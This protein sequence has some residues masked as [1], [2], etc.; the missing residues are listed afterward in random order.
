MG[1]GGFGE[2][3]C[4]CEVVEE[5]FSTCLPTEQRALLPAHSKQ[6]SSSMGKERVFQW[7]CDCVDSIVRNLQTVKV[8]FGLLQT[9]ADV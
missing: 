3:Y 1:P 5:G 6:R 8:K 7:L 4:L 2:S 9:F